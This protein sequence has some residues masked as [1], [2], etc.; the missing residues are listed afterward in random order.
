MLALAVVAVL[1][2]ASLQRA[3]GTGVGLVVAP[4]MALLF[5]PAE[6]VLLTNATTTLSGLLLTLTVWNDVDWKKI[7]SLSAWAIPGAI[8]GAF[9]VSIL[10]GSA[11]QIIIGVIV[12]IALLVTFVVPQ[13]PEVKSPWAR[14]TAGAMGGCFNTTAGVAAP[15][16]VIYANMSRWDQSSF[17]ATM[18]PTFM[19][20]GLMS[21]LLKVLVFP[22][23]GMTMP[24]WWLLP[25]LAVTILL[26]AVIGTAISKRISK[27]AA[28]NVANTLA[29]IGGIVVLLR[30]LGVL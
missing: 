21:V 30:G 29:L 27:K 10:P 22:V 8:L 14:R 25:V 20:M 28:R 4:V 2:G 19:V 17:A 3:S 5:G 1:I 23:P 16:M 6:G 13:L 7:R 18:Q 11:L 12:L 24:P 15:A 26:G 9:L